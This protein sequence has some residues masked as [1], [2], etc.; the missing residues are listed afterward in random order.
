MVSGRRPLFRQH[1]SRCMFPWKKGW[2]YYS[3]WSSF[4]T[5]SLLRL[6]R[7]NRSPICWNRPGQ[8]MKSS[9]P[10]YSASARI[11]NGT[12]SRTTNLTM[13]WIDVFKLQKQP[14][15]DGCWVSTKLWCR[16]S[17]KCS[18]QTLAVSFQVLNDWA[19]HNTR[20]LEFLDISDRHKIRRYILKNVGSGSLPKQSQFQSLT[21]R[22]SINFMHLR[23][24]DPR[25]L[26]LKDFDCVGRVSAFLS[27]QPEL[28]GR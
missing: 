21:I 20:Y 26:R 12:H 3:Q 15:I 1:S 9:Y 13:S 25:A 5:A 16:Y 23:S 7:K 6:R 18:F 14:S 8:L 11:T 22:Q 17:F 2:L 19:F 28:A 4:R 27:L 24:V 10:L